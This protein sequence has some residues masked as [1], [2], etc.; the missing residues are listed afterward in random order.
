L[1]ANIQRKRDP[2][3]K[4]S[5]VRADGAGQPHALIE[6]KTASIL[7]WSFT[8]DGK[9]LA[10]MTPTQIWTVPVEEQSGQLK[11]GTPERFLPSGLN[12]ITPAFSPDGRWL[13]YRSNASGKNEIYV[14]AFPP[15]SASSSGSAGPG[16]Q[17]Q[18]S[19]NGGV[20]P[21]WSRKGHEL[22]YVSG[23]QVMAVAYTVK[24]DAFVAD[25]PR[26]WIAK[27]GFVSGAVDA[28]MGVWDLA[29]DG[30][31]AAV[32]TPV[33]SADAPTQEHEVVFLQNFLDELRRRVPLGK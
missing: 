31:R 10:Y 32:L 9:R 4:P 29:P 3:G 22:F 18:I 28:T 13:A 27:A 1:K 16:G 25:K 24:G 8:P 11:A 2:F 21:I 20:Q 6:S 19:N 12:N 33:E 26:V 17:W 14:R 30:T 15:P 23:D 5:P 7:P